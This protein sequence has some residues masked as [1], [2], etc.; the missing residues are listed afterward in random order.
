[1]SKR[2]ETKKESPTR[3]RLRPGHRAVANGK[4]LRS[5]EVG[6]LPMID[7]IMSRMRLPEIL[8]RVLQISGGKLIS[9]S[10]TDWG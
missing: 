3:R 8:L 5:Y 7:R 2:E 1:M 9:A 6:A 4:S 10:S